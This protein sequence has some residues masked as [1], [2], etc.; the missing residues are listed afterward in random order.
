MIS[1]RRRVLSEWRQKV[2]ITIS[3]L[4][5]HQITRLKYLGKKTKRNELYGWFFNVRRSVIRVDLRR[6]LIAEYNI[7]HLCRSTDVRFQVNKENYPRVNG[8]YRQLKF[9]FFFLQRLIVFLPSSFLSLYVQALI[10][11]MI[12]FSFFIYSEYVNVTALSRKKRT[13]KSK[14]KWNQNLTKR[15]ETKSDDC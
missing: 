3:I 2:N 8:D 7:E 14:R 12:A 6:N 9:S 11:R 5:D 4:V 1:N 10:Y 15:D 13:R